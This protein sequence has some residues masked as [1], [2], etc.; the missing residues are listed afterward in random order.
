MATPAFDS[1]FN[2]AFEKYAD[3]DFI[4]G[5]NLNA[6]IDSIGNFPNNVVSLN[7]D[8]DSQ[9]PNGVGN[10]LFEVPSLDDLGGVDK[11]AELAKEHVPE[12]VLDQVKG[13]LPEGM[14]DLLFEIPSLDDLGGLD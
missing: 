9:A 11:L 3:D 2:E 10:M 7:G 1:V 6:F 4:E 13:A 14:G 8:F 5:E 12:P